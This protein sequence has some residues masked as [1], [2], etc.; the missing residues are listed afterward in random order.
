[1]HLNPGTLIVFFSLKGPDT[2]RSQHKNPLT[3]ENCL[4]KPS[5]KPQCASL[6]N[7]RIPIRTSRGHLGH[8]PYCIGTTA[9]NPRVPCSQACHWPILPGERLRA[10]RSL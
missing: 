6:L 1:M 9:L 7:P 2:P 8:A 10:Q 3:T 5:A 4:P